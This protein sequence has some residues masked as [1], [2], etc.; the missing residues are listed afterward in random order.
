MW[1]VRGMNG[2]KIAEGD[3]FFDYM[4]GILGLNSLRDM[5]MEGMF[6]KADLVGLVEPKR[7][8]D[9]VP[10]IEGY[11]LYLSLIHI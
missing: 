3:R 8:G 7:G 1:N 6:A 11:A 10:H 5:G 9:S 4:L 2:K